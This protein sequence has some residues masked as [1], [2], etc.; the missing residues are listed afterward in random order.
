MSLVFGFDIVDYTWLTHA[1]C[2]IAAATRKTTTPHYSSPRGSGSTLSYPNKFC[3]GSQIWV[4]RHCVHDHN[5]THLILTIF[6][7]LYFLVYYTWS[8]LRRRSPRKASVPRPRPWKQNSSRFDAGKPRFVFSGWSDQPSS[9]HSD[10]KKARVQVSQGEARV[11]SL[12]PA[13]DPCPSPCQKKEARSIHTRCCNEA[14]VTSSFVFCQTWLLLTTRTTT[15]RQILLGA[16]EPYIQCYTT[17]VVVSQHL[18][19][20]DRAETTRWHQRLF[21]MHG[22]HRNSS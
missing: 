1:L 20:T 16:L 18:I 11:S 21:V 7:I 10:R 5:S 17:L 4:L 12:Q 3:V 19:P 2:L 13:I 8:S 15:T 22:G 14:R 6:A 9:T